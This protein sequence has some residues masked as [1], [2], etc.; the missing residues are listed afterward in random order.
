MRTVLGCLLCAV[1]I[2]CHAATSDKHSNVIADTSNYDTKL[3]ISALL[4]SLEYSYVKNVENSADTSL[5]KFYK[6]S[7]IEF[8]SDSIRYYAAES[9]F[10]K[11][12]SSVISQLLLFLGD[13][14]KCTW[15]YSPDPYSSNVRKWEFSFS[16]EGGAKVLIYSYILSAC[17][18]GEKIPN[19]P[20][21]I[22]YIV[23]KM[24]LKVFAS[25]YK[26]H[27]LLNKYQLCKKFKDDI[28]K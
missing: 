19:T 22:E 6:K 9:S 10:F 17:G 8:K 4:D 27:Y 3:A 13:S 23:N 12:D 18:G 28:I 14:S 20:I 26:S 5:L 24:D 21:A 7:P 16:K 2:S 15:I 1:L 11:A 25:W